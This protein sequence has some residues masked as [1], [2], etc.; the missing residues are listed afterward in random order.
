MFPGEN[1]LYKL[2]DN[3]KAGI[4]VCLNQNEGGEPFEATVYFKKQGKNYEELRGEK[5]VVLTAS[6][7]LR[8]DIGKNAFVEIFAENA[9]MLKDVDD[10]ETESLL[11]EDQDGG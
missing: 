5:A 3:S 7:K 1:P 8:L 4:T 2:P 9:N 10:D 11:K 6:G